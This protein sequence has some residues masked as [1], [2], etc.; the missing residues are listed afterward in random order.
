MGELDLALDLFTPMRLAH[1]GAP[2]LRWS[3]YLSARGDFMTMYPFVP[4]SE[5]VAL[6]DYHDMHELIARWLGYDVF[7]D[8][9]PAHDPDRRPYWTG[10]YSDAG[11]AGLMVS[12]A[13]PAS[14]N[15]HW[16]GI[17]GTDILLSYLSDFLQRIDWPVGTV[18]IVDNSG[19]VL[20]TR[21]GTRAF[22]AVTSA[23]QLPQPLADLPL[24]QVLEAERTFRHLEGNWVVT[25][26]LGESPFSLLY[27]VPDHA[28]M[29]L[30][31]PRFKPYALILAT[32]MLAL[33]AAH[34]LLQHRFVR[35]ALL[36]VRHIQNESQ[37][38]E[39]V[40]GV[41]LL[42]RPWFDAVSAAFAGARTYQARLAESEA[43]LK[44]AA[45]S[46]PDGLAIFNSEDRLAFYN[47]HYPEHLVDGLR[48]TMALGKRWSDWGREAA[49]LGP[50]YHPEMGEA[51]LERRIEDRSLAALDREH[52]LADGR[53][54]RVRE[55]R[56]RDGGRVLLTTDTTV[57]RRTAGAR[58]D[59]HGNGA[60][61]Q[62]DRDRRH[63]LPAA[64]R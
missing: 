38:G 16:L 43:R 44:A 11:G 27:A 18:W 29:G 17:I 57:E 4:S 21:F 34:Y 59:R 25:E 22:P 40:R 36:L 35:P 30:I 9:T 12:H 5:F 23:K 53:W 37:G 46:I 8:G 24:A 48:A 52:R 64:L 14:T 2:Q 6:G 39:G 60:G 42:W 28:L 55:S 51:Y 10:V 62:L 7:V 1:L 50:L 32:L 45:E 47:S 20:A 41:P 63:R 54:V 56:M 31:L 33:L 49:T 15:S 58:P 26:R 13:A 3:Y 19:K 61:R